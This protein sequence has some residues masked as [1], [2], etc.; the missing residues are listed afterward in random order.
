[1][2]KSDNSN[3]F[4]IREGFPALRIKGGKEP[5]I[6]GDEPIPRFPFWGCREALDIDSSVLESVWKDCRTVFSA[7]AKDGDQA[8]SAGITYFCPAAMKPRC[9]LEALA[10]D[11]FRIHT[12]H[13]DK[14]VMIHEQS[15]AEWWTLVLDEDDNFN[16]KSSDAGEANEDDEESDEVGLHFDA[17]Y[18]LE[19]QASGLLLHPRL[20]TVTYLSNFGA[21]T[22]V[23]DKR[24][25]PPDDP[26]K[27]SLEGDISKAWL[28]LP[29]IGKHIAFDGR[30]LHGAPATFFPATPEKPDSSEPPLKKLKQHRVRYTFLVNIWVNHCPLD[31]ELLDDDILEHLVIP[32]PGKEGDAPLYSW[33]PL[34]LEE[35]SKCD[36]VTLE[37]HEEDPAG[38][39][40]FVLCD[41]LITVNYG[42]SMQ[43]LHHAAS[44]EKGDSVQLAFGP[45][46]ISLHVGDRVED[47][48]SDGEDS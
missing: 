42:A 6:D 47:D 24:S 1:M 44:G 43:D 12:K 46:T 19:E 14:G 37:R 18:G 34:T 26:E 23:F 35:R 36:T 38:E 48:D 28:S 3:D 27:K 2:S 4:V 13:L 22:V 5:W 21:P 39:E 40:E 7:R 41:H 9:A 11:I 20:A 25:P 8:Y 33:Q 45:G 16:L 15:G 30:L 17:D 10:L 29:V 32:Y 31:A